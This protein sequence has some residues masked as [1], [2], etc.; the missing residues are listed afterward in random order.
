MVLLCLSSIV[1]DKRRAVYSKA[2]AYLNNK[3]NIIVCA[4][5]SSDAKEEV[6]ATI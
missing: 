5:G 6:F 2:K 4:K 3:L 1:D